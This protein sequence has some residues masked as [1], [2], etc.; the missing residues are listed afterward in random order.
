[1][2][3]WSKG[4]RPVSVQPAQ[5]IQVPSLALITGSM[6]V[7]IPPGELRHSGLPSAPVTRSTGSRLATMTRSEGTFF[8][9]GPLGKQFL[10]GSRTLRGRSLFPPDAARVLMRQLRSVTTPREGDDGGDACGGI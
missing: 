2:P 9:L 7:T 5:L 4:S 6:A 8:T 1:M 10:P 3:S